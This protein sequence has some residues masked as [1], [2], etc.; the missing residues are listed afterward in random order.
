MK[1]LFLNPLAFFGGVGERKMKNRFA[2]FSVVWKMKGN[3]GHTRTKASQTLNPPH[4]VYKQTENVQ[5][6]F[7]DSYEH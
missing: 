2:C 4:V 5:T 6:K 7:I 3:V 1:N